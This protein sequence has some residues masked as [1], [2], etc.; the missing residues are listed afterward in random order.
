METHGLNF[1]EIH[2]DVKMKERL[3]ALRAK[4]QLTWNQIK[5][6]EEVDLSQKGSFPL[7]PSSTLE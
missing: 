6:L 5:A 7:A 3:R 4:I 1:R 2:M